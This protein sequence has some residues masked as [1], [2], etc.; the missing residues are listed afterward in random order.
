MKM[1]SIQKLKY[2][3]PYLFGGGNHILF[4]ISG[5]RNGKG[6]GC[7]QPDIL[8]SIAVPGDQ[9][10]DTVAY[11]STLRGILDNEDLVKG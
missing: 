8:P 2:R 7:N 3:F 10:D 6:A 5:E 4:K 11:T 9:A 1:L